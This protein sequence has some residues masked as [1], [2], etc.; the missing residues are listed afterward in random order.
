MALVTGIILTVSSA[1][2]ACTTWVGKMTVTGSMTHNP[3]TG[4][5]IPGGPSVVVQG[6]NAAGRM[7]YCVLGGEPV[8]KAAIPQTG[9]SFTIA[10]AP[11]D[12]ECQATAG[13]GALHPLAG[14][15]TGGTV[16]NPS[17]NRFPAGD[18]YVTYRSTGF[19]YTNVNDAP[20]SRQYI[21]DCMKFADDTGVINRAPTNGGDLT[22]G[23]TMI[24]VNSSGVGSE[25]FTGLNPMGQ[26]L[27]DPSRPFTTDESAICVS[28]IQSKLVGGGSTQFGNQAPFFS[29]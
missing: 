11:A 3:T 22:N 12:P 18:Y 14:T 8:G 19:E 6:A 4:A 25:T 15:G 2:A 26:N 16:L 24:T 9:G 1:A 29:F 10:I 21:T 28:N 7:D 5:P 23:D 17:D 13:G 20:L 27:W